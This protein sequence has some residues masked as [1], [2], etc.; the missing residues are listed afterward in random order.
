MYFSAA[1]KCIHSKK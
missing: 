1:G